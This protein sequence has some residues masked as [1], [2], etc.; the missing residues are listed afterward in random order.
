MGS[1][2]GGRNGGL[3]PVSIA[4]SSPAIRLSQ[5]GL[6][7]FCRRPAVMQKPR[8]VDDTSL[9]CQFRLTPLA[10]RNYPLYNKIVTFCSFDDD[11]IS[12]VGKGV[13]GFVAYL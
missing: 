9:F 10:A 5:G 2:S 3:I 6:L 11:H 4:H 12:L 13:F 8:E 7:L 1:E